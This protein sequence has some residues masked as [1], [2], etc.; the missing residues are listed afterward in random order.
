MKSLLRWSVVGLVTLLGALTLLG[1]LDRWTPY[2]ELATFHRLQYAV[3]LGIAALVA[4]P[5]R[6]YRVG[7][8]ALLLAGVNLLVISQVL[9]P[10]EAAAAD[11]PRL[12]LLVVNVEYGNDDHHRVAEL[13]RETNPDIVGITELTPEWARGLE[14]ALEDYP[15]RRLAPQDGA[16]GIGLFSKVPLHGVRVEHFPSDGPPS[17]LATVE[18]G[19]QSLGLVITHVHTPF[20]GDIHDRHLKALA[21]RRQELGDRLAICGDFNAVPW[22]HPVR[23]LSEGAGLRSVQGRFGLS[24][25]WPADAGILRIP[26]DNCLVSEGIAVEGRRVG[27]DIGSDHLPLIVELA[28]A[29]SDSARADQAGSSSSEVT[30]PRQ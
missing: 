13:I 6:S 5:L 18:L 2:L 20:A 12:R 11:A 3:L 16:Y 28:P 23:D 9:S 29:V 10:P 1:L 8:V 15:E 19:A 24:G 21:E 22:S 7:L 4:I 30:V 26:I 27:P 14:A 17:V 25:T